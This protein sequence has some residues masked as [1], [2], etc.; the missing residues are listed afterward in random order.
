VSIEDQ[1]QI[2]VVGAGGIGCAVGY[3]LLAARFPVVFVEADVHKIRWGRWRGVEINHRPV[4]P[5]QFISFAEWQPPPRATVLLCTKCFDNSQVLA[6]LPS[7]VMLV[8]IQNGFDPA[9]DG[10]IHLEGI[11]SFVSECEPGVPYTRITRRGHLHFGFRSDRTPTDWPKFVTALQ[12]CDLFKVEVVPNILPFK[13]SK[14]MYNAAIS[15]LAVATG[16]DNGHLLREPQVRQL[17]FQLLLENYTI[18]H[19]A[20]IPLGKIGPFHPD[21]VAQ[22]LHR[23]W[24]ARALAWAFYPGLR[25]TYCSMSPYD[26]S[27][28]R[29]EI[30]YFNGHLI[31]L[32]DERL[33][34][35]NRRVYS[36]IKRME[37]ERTVP[38]LEMLEE[39]GLH[40]A[41]SEGIISSL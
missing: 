15:P 14:L 17:F 41:S 37:S 4:L 39:I 40:Y 20:R 1:G 18:L 10:R 22:I 11:A 26:L 32:A 13:Y 30:D 5:A 16:F 19:E 12:S 28:G 35:L 36:F 24:I 33:C 7:D 21:H 23:P 6:R 3:G 8:P 38:S 29:T 34:P 31:D 9:L 27:E 2:F 25:G